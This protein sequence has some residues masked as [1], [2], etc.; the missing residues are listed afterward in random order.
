MWLTPHTSRN[1]LLVSFDALDSRVLGSLAK[2]FIVG[3]GSGRVTR[4]PPLSLAVCISY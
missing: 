1:I 4:D 3:E 2:H